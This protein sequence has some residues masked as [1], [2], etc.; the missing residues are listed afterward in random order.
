LP[1]FKF[2]KSKRIFV[3]AEEILISLQALAA[4]LKIGD[5]L[6]D[7][8]RVNEGMRLIRAQ[9][10]EIRLLHGEVE[11]RARRRA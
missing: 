11:R 10:E 3:E 2:K 5:R 9:E 6:Y 7:A 4:E 8:H 1:A